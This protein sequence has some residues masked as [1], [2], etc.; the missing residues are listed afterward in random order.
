MKKI[1]AENIALIGDIHGRFEML[2]HLISDLNIQNSVII[3]V[4][5]FGVGFNDPMFELQQ[6]NQLT[7]ILKPSN[8]RL[9]VVRGNHDDPSYFLE[10]KDL[11]NITFI[12]DYTYIQINEEVFLFAGGA[13]SVDRIDRTRGVDWFFGEPM[14]PIPRGLK[15][16]DVL[17]THTG[18]PWIGPIEKGCHY[19]ENKDDPTLKDTCRAE[20][21]LVHKLIMKVKPKR[22]YC[23]HF[24]CSETMRYVDEKKNVD[25]NSKILHIDEVYEHRAIS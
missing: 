5:D 15:P 19:F 25:V 16:C 4:G 12:K 8:N 1:E 14:P 3:Q 7:E 22:H 10:T 6:L 2:G 13:V 17:I 24:H 20:R 18:P 21:K 9:L 11:G 23:G